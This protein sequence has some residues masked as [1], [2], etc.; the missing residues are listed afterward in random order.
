[1]LALLKLRLPDVQGEEQDALLLSL[2]EEAGA[3][4]CNLT[5]R[6]QVPEQLKNAQV[7]LAAALF[8]RMGAEGETSRREGD[9]ERVF[10]DLPGAVKR[11]IMAYRMAR[12]G[13][14]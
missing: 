1:M 4:I 14:G 9:V 13:R 7:R 3:M 6:E 8:G 11:E 2:L 5:W 12:T 10:E